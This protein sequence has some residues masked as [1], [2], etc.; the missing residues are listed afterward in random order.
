MS[1]CWWPAYGWCGGS[2]GFSLP[3]LPPY[4]RWSRPLAVLVG[5]TL[6]VAPLTAV[7]VLRDR[8]LGATS[9]PVTPSTGPGP[10]VAPNGAT[11]HVA[12][13]L[14]AIG[15]AGGIIAL[16]ILLALVGGT[17]RGGS[18]RRA[19]RPGPA[20]MTGGDEPRAQAQATLDWSV[21]PGWVAR[22]AGRNRGVLTQRWS[23]RSPARAP[24]Q[25]GGHAGRG[26]GPGDRASPLA[27]RAGW[28]WTVLFREA[29]YSAH[30][31]S[32]RRTRRAADAL[33]AQLELA[34]GGQR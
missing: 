24:L 10:H 13:A 18:R 1:P 30:T 22:P 29:R 9:A 33:L 19:R 4:S 7:V 8:S 25:G 28:R 3:E 31:I 14:P 11:G 5:V 16:L 32:D 34:L 26:S 20:T 6:A 12:V 15:V 2:G 21:R 23:A 27:R 17:G